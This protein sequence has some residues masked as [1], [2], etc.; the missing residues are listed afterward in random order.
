M[1]RTRTRTSVTKACD[2]IFSLIIRSHGRCERCGGIEYLQP[3]HFKSRRY[4]SLRWDKKNANCLDSKCHMF[5]HDN[6]D[7]HVKWVTLNYPDRIQY[8]NKTLNITKT[9]HIKDYLEIE[10]KLKKQLAELEK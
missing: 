4:R 9:W 10:K 1:S 2:K 8:L 6:P 3:A 5:F 7:E